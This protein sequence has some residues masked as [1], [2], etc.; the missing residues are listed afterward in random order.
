M[1]FFFY[2]FRCLEASLGFNF[3][4]IVLLGQVT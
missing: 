1:F 3:L 4:D 2:V